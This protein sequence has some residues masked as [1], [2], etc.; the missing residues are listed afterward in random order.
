MKNTKISLL[1]STAICL[2]LGAPSPGL[3]QD[4]GPANVK[5]PPGDWSLTH[6]AISRIGLADAPAKIVST[7]GDVKYGGTITKIGLVNHSSKR[8]NAVKFRWYLFREESPKEIV[9]K[10][11][12]PEIGLGEFASG[13][14]REVEYPVVSFGSVYEPLVKN[15]KLMGRFVIETAVSEILYADGT[16]WKRR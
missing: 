9:R 3:C 11:E 8:I 2:A 16:R 6:P 7:T 13:T 12:T 10:G 14:E 15:G 5:F 4:K 1:V